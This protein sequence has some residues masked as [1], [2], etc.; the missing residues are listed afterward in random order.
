MLQNYCGDR[1]SKERAVAALS[2]QIE[3]IYRNRRRDLV[4]CSSSIL[5]AARTRNRM[6]VRD[7]KPVQLNVHKTD[8]DNQD[9]SC[10]VKRRIYHTNPFV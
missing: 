10:E 7:L 9:F 3:E 4:R 2:T 1:E 5:N 6:M 8:L